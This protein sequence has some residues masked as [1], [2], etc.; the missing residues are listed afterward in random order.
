MFCHSKK[1]Q[2]GK[3]TFFLLP[4]KLIHVLR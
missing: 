4:E 1:A 2:H 3:F